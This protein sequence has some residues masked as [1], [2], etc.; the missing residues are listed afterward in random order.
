MQSKKQ[1]N[2]DILVASFLLDRENQIEIGL[3]AEY[4]V[5]AT[6]INSP[7]KPLVKSAPFLE[8]F[9]EL[10]GEAIPVI[11]M[12][13]RL[14]CEDTN[15]DELTAKLAIIKLGRKHYG[16]LFDDIKDVLRVAPNEIASLD[17]I[18]LSEDV[19][20]SGLIVIENGKRRL[21]LIDLE[22]IFDYRETLAEEDD[23]PEKYQK[24]RTFSWYVVF[25]C[26]GQDYGV[27][28]DVASEIC[29][30]SEIDDIFSIDHIAGVV[31]LRDY[32]I[33]ILYSEPLLVGAGNKQEK[34][35]D[36]RGLV[37]RQSTFSF[38]LMVDSIKEIVHMADDEVLEVPEY[39]LSYLKGIYKH[40]GKNVMLIDIVNLVNPY[41]ADIASLCRKSSSYV[42]ES[43]LASKAIHHIITE[44]S[45]LIFSIGRE[46]AIEL[47]D[48][49]EI[50]ETDSDIK[51][52]EG[53]GTVHGILILRG[54]AIPVLN[55]SKFYSQEEPKVKTRLKKIII[56]KCAGQLLALEVEDIVTIYKQE[57][58]FKTPS[59]RSNLSPLKDTLDRLLEYV[60]DDEIKRHVLV[61]NIYNIL[62]NHLM[63]NTVGNMNIEEAELLT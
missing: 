46:F 60:G 37:I 21:E 62:N 57:Q 24:A 10:R 12:K 51:L 14:G 47:K 39:N 44:N 43:S 17:P 7:I 28:V 33:P 61:L 27:N 20:S 16:L 48:V 52:I 22:K 38:G 63:G 13:V 40:R 35:E 54:Q 1:K 58:F 11:N 4:V 8:G 59:L 55:L 45:Y 42:E 5:E 32:T 31:Q 29:F 19:V 49:Q 6:S 26:C 25:T 18:L 2:K 3:P 36:S 30:L 23:L 15:Y 50:I 34:T 53:Q 41:Q 9:I 56:A